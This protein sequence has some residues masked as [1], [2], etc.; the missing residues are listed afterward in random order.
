MHNT[1]IAFVWLNLFGR[2][3]LEAGCRVDRGAFADEL[4]PGLSPEKQRKRL[5]DRLDDMVHRD[6]PEVLF[7]RLIVDPYQLRLHLTKC[8]IAI[9][10]LQQLAKPCV[11]SGGLLT[12]DLLA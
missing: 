5:R 1:V 12:G 4:S 9:G 10:R 3:L 11:A 8:S 7:S 6:L 2:G